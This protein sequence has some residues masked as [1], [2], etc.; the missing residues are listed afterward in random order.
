MSLKK[1]LLCFQ[2]NLFLLRNRLIGGWRI[3]QILFPWREKAKSKWKKCWSA[4]EGCYLVRY[5]LELDKV[6]LVKNPFKKRD[7]GLSFLFTLYFYKWCI[8]KKNLLDKKKWLDFSL[9]D[10]FIRFVVLARQIT[11]SYELLLFIIHLLNISKLFNNMNTL[12]IKPY[13]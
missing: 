9:F 12:V 3:I 11:I 13:N 1:G 6:N 10:S 7:R 2:T 5:Y 8:K 4:R